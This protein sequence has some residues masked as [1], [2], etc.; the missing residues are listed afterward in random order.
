MT[1]SVTINKEI[2]TTENLAFYK[3]DFF[4]HKKH[5]RKN[6]LKS[7]RKDYKICIKSKITFVYYAIET[8]DENVVFFT[9]TYEKA[10][11]I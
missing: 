8:K 7:I 5:Q 3:R 11:Q 2:F 1:K 6:C 10:K 9:K 4:G